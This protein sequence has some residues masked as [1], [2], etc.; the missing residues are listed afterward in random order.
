MDSVR[1]TAAALYTCTVLLL[2]CAHYCCYS[3]RVHSIAVGGYTSHGDR[4]IGCLLGSQQQ[5]LSAVG[6]AETTAIMKHWSS[7]RPAPRAQAAARPGI[8]RQQVTRGA[9]FDGR[10]AVPAGMMAWGTAC[11]TS[12]HWLHIIALR[13]T[14]QQSTAQHNTAKHITAHWHHI[15]PHNVAPRH[16]TSHHN[17][18]TTSHRTAFR[19]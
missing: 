14:S 7:G 11:I 6:R 12:L 9:G 18:T 5:R 4:S 10:G 2:R 8:A 17:T 15:P 13:S 19:P 16:L 3:V 1:S